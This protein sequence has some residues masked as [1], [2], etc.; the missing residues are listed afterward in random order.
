[1]PPANGGAV[2]EPTKTRH[3]SSQPSADREV[4][5]AERRP[6]WPPFPRMVEEDRGSPLGPRVRRVPDSPELF[7]LTAIAIALG[8]PKAV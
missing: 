2:E 6:N 1:M 5:Q 4:G 3:A 8:G 7:E